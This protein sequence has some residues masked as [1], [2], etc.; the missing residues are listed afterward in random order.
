MPC[1][2]LYYIMDLA[3]QISRDFIS[4][5]SQVLLIIS[6]SQLTLYYLEWVSF[7]KFQQ[8]SFI[9]R[10]QVSI[11]LASSQDNTVGSAEDI[12]VSRILISRIASFTLSYSYLNWYNPIPIIFVFIYP[13]SKFR[14]RNFY[15]VGR[16]QHPDPRIRTLI[17]VPKIFDRIVQFSF[18][19]CVRGL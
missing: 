3:L 9:S 14:G 4:F 1:R 11:I 17:C 5:V 12:Q 18:C 19:M 16:L 6:P 8:Y 7:L 13:L 2:V 15:L 10:H